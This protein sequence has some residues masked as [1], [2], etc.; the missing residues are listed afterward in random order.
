MNKLQR[1][2]WP[3]LHE[4]P[5]WK[6]LDEFVVSALCLHL[7]ELQRPLCLA[8][9]HHNASGVDTS[10]FQFLKPCC[11]SVIS[12]KKHT[13]TITAQVATVFHNFSAR[14]ESAVTQRSCDSS[15]PFSVLDCRCLIPFLTTFCMW[16]YI[17]SLLPSGALYLYLMCNS[18]LRCRHSY[19]DWWHLIISS[20][21]KISEQCP[22]C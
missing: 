5:P 4:R 18:F 19:W 6:D 11:V 15:G 20:L 12:P 17:W 10:S 9:P 14:K 7:L 22:P 13:T 3:Q 21:W 1:L 8:G 16:K 2:E